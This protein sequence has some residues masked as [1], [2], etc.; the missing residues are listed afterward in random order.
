MCDNKSMEKIGIL[1]GTFDPIHVEHV[2]LAK[3]A[4]EELGLTKLLIMPTRIPPHKTVMPTPAIDR[5]AMLKLA[6]DGVDRVE[7]SDFEITNEGKS[8][9]Y[10]TV[11]HFKKTTG[12]ELYFIV[13]GDMIN[14]FKNWKYPERI[15]NACTLCAF[16]R[17]DYFTDYDTLQ[18]YFKNTFG[19]TFTKLSYVGKTQSSTEIRT[20]ASF[21]LSVEG[22]TDARVAEYIKA[23]DLYKGDKYVQFIKDNLPEKR[24]IHTANVVITALKKV[25]ELKLDSEK[26]RISATLHDCAKYMD[27][28][29][30][31]GFILPDGVPKPVVHAF[32][33]AFVAENILGVTDMEIIDAIR[34]HT[35]GKANMSLLG[36]L[37]FVA[38]MVEEGRDYQ[39]VDKLRE[40]YEKQDFE[41]CF[42]ECLKEE[43]LHLIN[44]K[45]YIYSET[46]NA[47]E[48][49]VKN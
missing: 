3:S 23:N 5:I 46:V 29:K 4:I 35:S 34:Y 2:R 21:G 18:E 43:F 28:T 20:K 39:G 36:K 17:E 44:K 16:G 48:Y 32:L 37:I 25:R 19:K 41:S 8:Y 45:Q 7:I 38:D 15:L 13:G 22:M 27:Y 30:V 1:G 10:L 24:I 6:F 40:L 33:G 49:Y 47:V 12:A 26:V 42:V 11:E 31:E 14:D 9:T